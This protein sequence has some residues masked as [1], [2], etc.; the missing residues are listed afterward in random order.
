[1]YDKLIGKPIGIL[2]TTMYY[3]G[4]LARVDSD[5]LVLVGAQWVGETGVWEEF[6]ATLVAAESGPF[7]AA[8]EVYV[9]LA[10]VV[11]VF[12]ADEKLVKAAKR[13]TPKF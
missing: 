2:T 8:T 11:I 12:G 1:M 3:T 5:S 6:A 10:Q 13:L 4:T 7:P 9:R